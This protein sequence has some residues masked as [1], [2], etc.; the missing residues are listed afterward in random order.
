[1]NEKPKIP[2]LKC[3]VPEVVTPGYYTDKQSILNVSRKDK[4][5]LIFSVPKLL[6]GK[7]LEDQRICHGGNLDKLHYS[8]WGVNIPQVNVPSLP[9][10]YAGQ[11]LKVSSLARDPYPPIE[12]NFTVDNKFDNY[13]VLWKWLN[14]MNDAKNGVFNSGKNSCN[15]GHIKDYS[16]TFVIQS[17]GEY[18]KPQVEWIFTDAFPT[19]IGQLNLSTRD[20][21][22]T[23]T[24][25][26]FEFSQLEMKLV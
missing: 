3:D 5:R 21:N 8:I 4:Y 12:V 16:E 17:L 11:T 1:M 15:K 10:S 24:A 6:R 23:E 9:I 20:S 7:F 13:Y 26:T 18:N 19:N 22:E 14:L 2:D 25:F